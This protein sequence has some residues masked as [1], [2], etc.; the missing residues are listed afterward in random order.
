MLGS[1][2]ENAEA[3]VWY[4]FSLLSP[5][6]TTEI[7]G[8]SGST[9]QSVQLT[10]LQPGRSYTYIIN[11]T[12]P[13]GNKRSSDPTN[14]T[15]ATEIRIQL[16]KGWNMVS[17][18]PFSLSVTISD[19]LANIAGQYD[20]VQVYDAQDPSGDYWKHYNP[21]K[22]SDLNDLISVNII[23]GFWILM[24]NDAILIPAHMD[25][26]TDPIFVA[27]GGSTAVDLVAGWN[28]VV[29]P[30]V[31]NRLVGPALTGVTYD[32]VW[33]FDGTQWDYNDG[34]SGGLAQFELGMGYWIHCPSIGTWNVD[35]V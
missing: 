13:E 30:S 8:S 21:G 33:A 3:Q 16:V 11:S 6:F 23:Q 5:V 18:P 26:T 7:T 14:Y 27:N 34:V 10:G 19:M 9:T 24:K 1:I 15:F 4:G 2:D 28:F 32:I 29:Y 35:Y 25:P 31:V 12:D 20:A 17:I 22:R